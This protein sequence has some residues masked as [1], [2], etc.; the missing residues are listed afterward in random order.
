MTTYDS[1]WVVDR[2]L[3]LDSVLLIVGLLVLVSGILTFAGSLKLPTL[4]IAPVVLNL[5]AT[6]LFYGLMRS[7]IGRLAHGYFSGTNLI[8]EGPWG[9][10]IGIGLCLFAGLAAMIRLTLSYL[11]GHK[12]LE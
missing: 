5:A 3:A 7:A 2:L 12:Q 6:F 4:P 11:K 10:A 9:F 1:D 8:P